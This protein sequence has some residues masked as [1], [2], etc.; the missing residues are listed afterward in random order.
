M[1]KTKRTIYLVLGSLVF[2]S[3][4][5]IINPLQASDLFASFQRFVKQIKIVDWPDTPLSVVV[6]GEG[7]SNGQEEKEL[8]EIFAKVL[9]SPAT[10]RIVN[11]YTVP[12]GK[13][14]VI[15][16]VSVSGSQSLKAQIRRSQ[17]DTDAIVYIIVET[18]A[19]GGTFTKIYQ[20][21]IEFQAG[22]SVWL[23]N[24]GGV[25]Q[26][27]ELRGYLTDITS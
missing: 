11:A 3:A 12:N 13:H 9:D 26:F 14:L 5:T 16:D 7:N 20:S 6:Q 10:A 24:G 17:A 27:F 2:L 18:G 1:T 15:T 23:F 4:I 8:V 19:Q 25:D 21:G 22:T